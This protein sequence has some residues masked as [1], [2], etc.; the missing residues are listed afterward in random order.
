MT[1]HIK[2]VVFLVAGACALMGQGAFAQRVLPQVD[3]KADV[4]PAAYE[5]TDSAAATKST[6][7]LRDV[8]QTVNVV[9][10]ALMHDQ[11]AASLQDAL[12][13][14]P[15]LGYSVGDGQRDQVMIRGFSGISDQFV[16]GVRDDALYF[17]DLSNIERVEVLKGPSSVLYGRGSAGGLVNRVTRKPQATPVNE[18]A[19][20]AGSHGQRRA[21][22]DAGAASEGKAVLM[23]LTGA[24]EDSTGFRQQYFL[25]REA[26]AP[27]LSIRLAPASTLLLAA[28]YLHDKRLADQ[29][30]PGYRGRP[31][32]VPVETYFG[33]ANGEQRAFVESDVRSASAVVDHAFSDT[34]K[35]HAVLRHYEYALD[36][37]YTGIGK[38]TD[39]A[40][41]TVGISQTRRTRDERGDYAQAE[42][43]QQF[44]AGATRHQLLA[45]LELGRQDK[46][47]RLVTRANVATYQLFAP[48]LAVLGALPDTLAPSAFNG[49]KFTIAGLYLQDLATLTPAWKLLAGLRYDRLAQRRDDKT[50]RNLDLER[51]DH[52][53]S[54]RVGAVYQPTDSASYY[55]SVSQSFQPIADSFVFYSN[56]DDLK[57]TE[58][59]NKEVGAKFDIAA[60]A[61]ATVSLFEMSQTNIQ[62][63]DPD[64]AGFALPAGK[65]RTRGLELSFAGQFADNWEAS[66][67]YALMRGQ[68]V[69]TPA[70]S[71]LLGKEAALTPRHSANLWLKRRLNGPWYVAGGVNAQ[72][73]RF[74]APDNAIALPGYAVAQLGAGYAEGHWDVTLTLK[75]LFNRKYFIAAHSG[76][77]DYNMPGEPRAL[78]AGVRYRF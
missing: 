62:Y 60:R 57:P 67:G 44:A 3:V 75:N 32:D 56:S 72:S 73:A 18:V 11:N 48:Q 8:P 17:R 71:A 22:F 37:N 33:A 16:D 12:Q 47:E 58:T 66:A 31:V 46:A 5:A 36:R 9:G 10:R 30:V 34:L 21:E 28:D 70:G 27:S 54:P 64:H 52:T 1:L 42:L 2:P 15:G 14:V 61:S 55:A 20:L 7:A 39:G 49:N 76:A 77:N 35:L 24:L 50:A 63:A 23:R 59:V 13:N 41:P 68:V 19:L 69:A 4:A 45:G 78:G 53:L 51:T 65:Q 38:I 74:A 40:V 26:V 43:S 29:G 25:K 6:A